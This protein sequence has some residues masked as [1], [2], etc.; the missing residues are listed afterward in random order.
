MRLILWLS[1]VWWHKSS[2]FCKMSSSGVWNHNT[3]PKLT[4]NVS[5]MDVLC[6]LYCTVSTYLHNL[7]NDLTYFILFYVKTYLTKK[8]TTVVD[9]K[10]LLLPNYPLFFETGCP[11]VDSDCVRVIKFPCLLFNWPCELMSG[12]E[13]ALNDGVEIVVSKNL[14]FGI[15]VKIPLWDVCLCFFVCSSSVLLLYIHRC[16]CDIL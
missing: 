12:M 4:K 1:S 13:P 10:L 11:N 2:N 5:A 3:F 15:V 7:S 16:M 8:Q 14:W 6:C 9:F